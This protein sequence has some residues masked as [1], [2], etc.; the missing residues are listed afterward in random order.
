MTY[1]SK[2]DLKS[3]SPNQLF[4]HI[5]QGKLKQYLLEDNDVIQELSCF[6]EKVKKLLDNV[7]NELN[8]ESINENSHIWQYVD[9]SNE[10]KHIVERTKLSKTR[11]LLNRIYPKNE[12]LTTSEALDLSVHNL[13]YDFELVSNEKFVDGEPSWIGD[14]NYLLEHDLGRKCSSDDKWKTIKGIKLLS[15]KFPY[16]FQLAF[17]IDQET[18]SEVIKVIPSYDLHSI[19]VQSHF[20]ADR[21]SVSDL[22]SIYDRSTEEEL[23]SRLKEDI[24]LAGYIE[25]PSV[26]YYLHRQC[27]LKD[28]YEDLFKI[29][30]LLKYPSLQYAFLYDRTTLPETFLK[31]IQLVAKSSSPK[32]T[33]EIIFDLWYK[34]IERIWEN[35]STF[36][37]EYRYVGIL[38]KDSPIRQ[39]AAE[40][41]KSLWECVPKWA[42]GVYDGMRVHLTQDDLLDMSS[43]IRDFADMN[44]SIYKQ[45]HQ[46]ILESWRRIISNNTVDFEDISFAGK[47][48]DYMI[49]VTKSYL[50]Q[51]NRDRN[52]AMEFWKSL[53]AYI[54]GE[55][56]L[57]NGMSGASNIDV[58]EVLTNLFVIIHPH[59]DGS[60]ID[61]LNKR[62][63]MFEG[64]N[65]PSYTEL[66]KRVQSECLRICIILR[67]LLSEDYYT[68]ERE[69]ERVAENIFCFL[70]KQMVFSCSYPSIY[71]N[72]LKAPLYFVVS[73]STK[74]SRGVKDKVDKM[75]LKNI[76]S[77]VDLQILSSFKDLSLSQENLALFRTRWDT[78]WP[79]EKQLLMNRQQNDIIM[80]MEMI[81]KII[82]NR[83]GK[84]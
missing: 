82:A 25:L 16:A 8:E 58:I 52:I 43:H 45:I 33:S 28:N 1:Y 84:E 26:L 36:Q 10:I 62:K 74:M 56:F 5:Q 6:L 53:W 34:S 19:L 70:L 57:W 60:E 75:I 37:D 67:T 22:I 35:L 18:I 20:L 65:I 29:L 4:S 9:L 64:W 78:E 73:L 76:A 42:Q 51:N 72:Y 3:L 32:L 49:N 39:D 77:I 30:N 24:E 55:K 14:L 21:T 2:D 81:E 27:I 12:E 61:Y 50:N 46:H 48:L 63:V 17:D 44:D 23:I 68:D 69:K 71:E 59:K 54:N 66:S 7:L 79:I 83:E 41:S 31:M 38:P 13:L 40:L 15:C 47:N 11:E 80:R